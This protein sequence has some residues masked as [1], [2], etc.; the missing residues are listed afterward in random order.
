MAPEHL[1]G[2]TVAGEAEGAKYLKPVFL[3][4]RQFFTGV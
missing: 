4:H 2:L 1:C 3:G